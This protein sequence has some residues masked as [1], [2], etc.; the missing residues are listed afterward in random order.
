M[1]VP[2]RQK[3]QQ[4][5]RLDEWRAHAAAVLLPKMRG[6]GFPARRLRQRVAVVAD[7][8]KVLFRL[9][10]PVLQDG[11]QILELAA[12]QALREAFGELAQSGESVVGFAVDAV[13]A[14]VQAA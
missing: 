9:V 4:L 8:L 2:R 14:E 5:D 3:F 11:A 1:C 13:R 7:L 12:R 6:V 10:L